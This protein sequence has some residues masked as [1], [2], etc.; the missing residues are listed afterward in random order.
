MNSRGTDSSVIQ[1]G[2]QFPIEDSGKH[3]NGH[4]KVVRLKGINP[5]HIAMIERLQ[6]YNGCDWTKILRELSNPDKHR[7]ITRIRGDYFVHGFTS[8]DHPNF[9]D[10]RN[11]VRRAYHPIHG[12]VDVKIGL[13]TTVTLDDGTPVTSALEEI[14]TQVAN[15]LILFKPEF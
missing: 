14:K 15:T 13:V 7:E 5:T 4:S 9:A 10:I 8:F 12:E 2:T 11:P 6:P 3:F 1:S